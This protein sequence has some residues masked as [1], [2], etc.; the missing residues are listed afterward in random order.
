MIMI[1][2]QQERNSEWN[3]S[4]DKAFGGGQ[5]LGEQKEA[6]R[7]LYLGSPLGTNKVDLV[8][9]VSEEDDG[10]SDDSRRCPGKIHL[11][12]F[13]WQEKRLMQ[14]NLHSGPYQRG[15]HRLKRSFN[16]LRLLLCHIDGHSSSVEYGL[17]SCISCSWCTLSP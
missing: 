17:I 12:K 2:V 11:S 3:S 9:I 13:K 6:S 8:C 7:T 10:C 14:L 15:H 16:S 5:S 4:G 1:R